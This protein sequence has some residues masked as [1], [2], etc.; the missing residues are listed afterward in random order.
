MFYIFN[1]NLMLSKCY[2]NV[3]NFLYLINI[4]HNMK[5]L[6]FISAFLLFFNMYSQDNVNEQSIELNDLIKVEIFHDNGELYQVGF[7]KNNK[8]HGRLESYD[9]NGNLAVIGEFNKGKKDGKW[10]FWNNEQIIEVYYNKNTILSHKS[11][12]KKIVA[13]N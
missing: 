7:L 3:N 4:K 5:N 11:W 1:V 6:I 12:I 10:F 9:I 13:I 2:V 8:L